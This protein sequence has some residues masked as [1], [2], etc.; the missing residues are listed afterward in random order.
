[1]WT[2]FTYNF[3]QTFTLIEKDLKK[4]ITP[5]Q[6]LYSKIELYYWKVNKRNPRQLL[7]CCQ[8]AE[9][10]LVKKVKNR[11]IKWRLQKKKS[12]L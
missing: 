1:M 11:N 4:A 5:N 8:Q 3:P 10:T 9:L 2:T 6:S 12:S 7:Q